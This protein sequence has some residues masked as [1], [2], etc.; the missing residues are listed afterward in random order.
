M[1]RSMGGH[2]KLLSARRGKKLDKI[3]SFNG[4]YILFVVYDLRKRR[5]KWEF[6]T[7]LC[8]IRMRKVG[9]EINA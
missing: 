3:L 2:S 8:Q 7:K 1:Y 5:Q 4:K 6:T 9:K